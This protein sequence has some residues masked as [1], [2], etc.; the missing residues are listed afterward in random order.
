MIALA[1]LALAQGVPAAQSSFAFACKV[2]GTLGPDSKLAP[3]PQKRPLGFFVVKNEAG[4]YAP[5]KTIDPTGLLSGK[6]ITVFHVPKPGNYGA[7]TGVTLQ[8]IA[9]SLTPSDSQTNNE[10]TL[11]F[12]MLNQGASPRLTVGKC[13]LMDGMTGPEFDQ[14]APMLSQ[15]K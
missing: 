13:L 7:A 5:S 6:Q 9:L 1:V 12:A 14:I 4:S 3:F 2:E 11:G 15:M 8:D 10:W